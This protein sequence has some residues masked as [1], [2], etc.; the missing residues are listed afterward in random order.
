MN[1]E[2]FIEIPITFEPPS[3]S[4]CIRYADIINYKKLHNDRPELN[5]ST[6]KPIWELL[7]SLTIN[8][9]FNYTPNAN[10]LILSCSVRSPIDNRVALLR[11]QSC[12]QYFSVS[13]YYA[14]EYVC[15]RFN[16]K[17]PEGA[18]YRYSD[19]GW[20]ITIPNDIYYIKL[21]RTT[22]PVIVAQKPYL[23]QNLVTANEEHLFGQWDWASKFTNASLIEESNTHATS[24]TLTATKVTTTRLKFPFKANCRDYKDTSALCK[25]ECLLNATLSRFNKIPYT[26]LVDTPYDVK[27]ISPIDIQNDTFYKE[28][29]NI[30]K[31]CY[32]KCSQPDCN[33]S[34]YFTQTMKDKWREYVIYVSS[35]RDPFISIS[36]RAALKPAE[37]VLYVLS[38]L[39]TWFGVSVL[40]FNP[41]QLFNKNSEVVNKRE[42][43][44][45]KSSI[46]QLQFIVSRLTDIFVL[47]R[48]V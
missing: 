16:H 1:T 47:R 36:F 13:K 22:L 24:F 33:E 17:F 15:Y 7:S 3:L 28:L 23:N 12:Y 6:D 26:V 9:I 34:L 5:V 20:D 35:P 44:A 30:E 39:G 19:V 31:F 40:S 2:V 29:K 48:S 46:A 32:H 41:F 11:G 37:F 25:Q 4:L 10:Y 21:N 18:T 45:I 14:Q 27:H 43:Q 42:I 8:E 38:C